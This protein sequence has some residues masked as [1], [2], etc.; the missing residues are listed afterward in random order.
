MSKTWRAALGSMLCL[1][2]WPTASHA[3]LRVVFDGPNRPDGYYIVI[4]TTVTAI[5][6]DPAALIRK[7][8][9]SPYHFP[10]DEPANLPAGRYYIFPECNG[11]VWPV[12]KFI[13]GA[14][15]EVKIRCP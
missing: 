6:R 1:L 2:L 7:V 13:H 10:L 3:K 8:R 15:L 12:G 4:D 9:A 5:L 14:Q 11:E